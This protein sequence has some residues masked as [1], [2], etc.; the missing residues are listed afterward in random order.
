MPVSTNSKF[1]YS[2][3]AV[4]LGGGLLFWQSKPEQRNE[5]SGRSAPSSVRT[6]LVIDQIVADATQAQVSDSEVNKTQSAVSGTLESAANSEAVEPLSPALVPVEHVQLRSI[7]RRPAGYADPYTE[8]ERLSETEIIQAVDVI[9]GTEDAS[10]KDRFLVLSLLN[11]KDLPDEQ[12]TRLLNYLADPERYTGMSKPSMHA[13]VNDLVAVFHDNPN[14]DDRYL[15]VSRDVINNAEE[16]EVVRDYTL[17]GLSRG[18]ENATDAQAA[19]IQQALWENV[20]RTDTS[21]AGTSLLALNRVNRM[22]ELSLEDR[23]RL[24]GIVVQN[25]SNSEVGERTRIS[26]MQVAAALEIPNIET[27]LSSIVANENATISEKI[28][29]KGVSNR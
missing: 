25:I 14:L 11:G 12:S 6:P 9:T 24:E 19:Y 1:V 15:E 7:S 3:A 29:A 23:A 2:L 18:Y 28:A 5:V 10:T 13:F 26:S 21:L 22:G 16:D 8:V 27:H 17:Q 20:K 4:L